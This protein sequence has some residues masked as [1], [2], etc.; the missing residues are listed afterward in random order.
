MQGRGSAKVRDF[1]L[2][3]ET[4]GETDEFVLPVRY[5]WSADY[6]GKALVVYGH[7]PVPEPQ[8]LNNTVNIDTGCVFGGRL[9]A[10][11]YPEREIVSVPAHATYYQSRK[12]FLPSEVL[13]ECASQ[14]VADDVLD[15]EDVT[16]KRIV[17]TRLQPRI[18]IRE[19]NAMAALEVM[20]RFAVDPKWLIYLPPTMSPTETTRMPGH[21][22]FIV[23]NCFEEFY[24]RFPNYVAT[25]VRK[26]VRGCV[27]R[28]RRKTGRKS[29]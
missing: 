25:W 2:Y 22:G 3:G 26:R 16:G 12:P 20:S 27:L 4:T 18:S 28:P 1:A 10:L 7:T 9:T 11:R 8:W 23:P 13:A 14:H 21:D 6:R 17:D 5:D 19:E 29:F 15:I 24:E